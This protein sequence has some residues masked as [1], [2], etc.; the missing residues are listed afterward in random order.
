MLKYIVKLMIVNED[1]FDKIE[2]DDSVVSDDNMPERKSE[3]KWNKRPGSMW[4]VEIL[5]PNLKAFPL[6]IFPYVV[7]NR[8]HPIYCFSFFL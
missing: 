7:F 4:S 8:L 2:I 1:F 3:R 5:S 6:I